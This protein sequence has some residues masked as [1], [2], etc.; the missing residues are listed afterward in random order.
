[1]DEARRAARVAAALLPMV[2]S[3]AH[4]Q[5]PLPTGF[6]PISLGSSWE[7]VEAAGATTMLTRASGKWEQNMVHCGYRSARLSVDQGSLLV[8][9]Q[10][11]TVTE[12]S[13]ATPIRAG[14]DLMQAAALVIETYGQP[15]R[16][17]LRDEFGT[18]TI[19][20]SRARYVV[21]EYV[22]P[23]EARF[24]ISGEPLWEHRIG[25]ADRNRRRLE[26]QTVR[27]ARERE[28]AAGR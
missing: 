5:T 24:S 16:A 11:A 10:H 7:T 25:I 21:L 22:G 12:L 3:L 2:A 17:T 8:T 27:C 15:E 23:V 9:A 13:Y 19:E 14:S 20:Q 18:V 28:K 4:A 26:N 6:G 1:M